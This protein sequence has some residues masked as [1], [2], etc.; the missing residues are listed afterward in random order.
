LPTF[1]WATIVGAD[2]F[3]KLVDLEPVQRPGAIRFDVPETAAFTQGRAFA[4][5]LEYLLEVGLGR[6]RAHVAALIDRLVAG[7][8]PDVALE[9]AIDDRQRSSIVRLVPSGD[10]RTVY[11]RL[12]AEGIKVSLREGGLRVSPGVWNT[13]ADIDRLLV[14]LRY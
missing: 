12:F 8:P 14:A 13:G 5:S 3:N 6:I 4:T 11:E 9:S 7:L 10:A 2:D 1:N